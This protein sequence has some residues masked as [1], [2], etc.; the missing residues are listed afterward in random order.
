VPQDHNIVY[1]FIHKKGIPS[2]FIEEI[3]F[4]TVSGQETVL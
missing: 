3:P 4:Y 2:L 1:L